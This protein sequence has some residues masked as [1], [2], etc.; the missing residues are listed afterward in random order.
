MTGLRATIVLPT[1]GR[2]GHLREC[3][4]SLARLDGGPW[5]VVVVD[6][7]S[8]EP[9]DAVCAGAGPEVRY[10]RQENAGP[11][12]RSQSRHRGGGGRPHPL[13]R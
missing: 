2:P 6:D 10:V 8:P 9:V 7:G 3:L 13:D 12:R 4:E 5:P 1:Y 11:R